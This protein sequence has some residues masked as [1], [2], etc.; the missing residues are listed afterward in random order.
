MIGEL[1][2]LVVSVPTLAFVAVI[3]VPYTYAKWSIR[4][5]AI[6]CRRA[7]AL[8]LT[9]DDGPGAEL[10]PKLV[11]LLRRHQVRATFFSLGRHVLQRPAILDLVVAEGHELGCHGFGHRH[12][13]KTGPQQAVDDI[14]LGYNTLARWMPPDGMFRPPYGKITLFTWL[15]VWKRGA[16]LAWWTHDSGDT[17]TGPLPLVENVVDEIIQ[18]GGGVVLMHDFDRGTQNG[19]HPRQEFVLTLTERLIEGTAKARMKTMTLGELLSVK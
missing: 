8:V 4:S 13:W 16:H 18:S 9:Y 5:L 11:E 6:R 7:K 14:A 2:I 10:T 3:L 17:R 12:S 19:R 1:I 15:A